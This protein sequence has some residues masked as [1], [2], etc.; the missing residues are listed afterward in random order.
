MCKKSFR[1]RGAK[2]PADDVISTVTTH[3]RRIYDKLGVHNKIELM[4]RLLSA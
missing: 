3:V 2:P 4:N 1:A